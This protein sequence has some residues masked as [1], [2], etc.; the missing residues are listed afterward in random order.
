MITTEYFEPGTSLAYAIGEGRSSTHCEDI[1][2][3]I[4]SIRSNTDSERQSLN[5]LENSKWR[6]TTI[7]ET[8]RM[9]FRCR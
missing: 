1:V 4:L 3:A 7:R 6:K 9:L 2:P 5:D 8:I